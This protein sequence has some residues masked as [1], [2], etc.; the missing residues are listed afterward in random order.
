MEDTILVTGAS[1]YIASHIVHQLIQQN[2]KIRGTVRSLSNEKKI[3]P[4]RQLAKGKEPLLEL[5]EADLLDKTSWSNAVKGCTYV[6]HVASP[7]PSKNPKNEDELISPAV[8]GTL[9]VLRACAQA[10][11]IKRVVLTSSDAAVSA[12]QKI[13][14]HRIFTEDDWTDDKKVNNVYTKSK[15]LAEKA[16]W[17]FMK[18]GDGE[19]SL[20]KFELVV[21][22]PGLVIGP[23]LCG[24]VTT[25]LEI[26][27]QMM[28]REMPL[29]PKVN[30]PMIDV[31]DV[32]AAHIAGLHVPEAAGHRHILTHENMWLT[33]IAKIIDAEFRK[34]G[35]NVPSTEAPYPL[36]WIAGRFDPTIKMLLSDVGR[37]V[38]HDNKRMTTILGI[39]PRDAKET[40]IDMCYSMVENGQIKKT[41]KYQPPSDVRL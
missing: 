36:L 24:E 37:V 38:L 35:Y 22:N 7:F 25:S 9:N 27:K 11:S 33:D 21:M 8:N 4:I 34:Q 29:V 1:G 17:E 32:A 15:T 18:K 2:V 10:G 3:Q 12:S 20:P 16:A 13:Y 39:R 6:M 28:Q 41:P 23:V 31:R 14:P 40:I 26:A 19:G 5:V 30:F